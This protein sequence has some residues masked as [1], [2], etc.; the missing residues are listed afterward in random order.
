[1]TAGVLIINTDTPDE[2]IVE[3]IKPYLTEFLMDPAIIGAPC[4][5]RKHIVSHI[6]QTRPQRTV[7]RYRQFWTPQGSPFVITSRAQQKALE[8]VLN[9]SAEKGEPYVVELAMRYGNPSILLGLAIIP[10][11]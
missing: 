1:M 4:F 8:E 3:V 9:A 11:L 7:K 2:P 10:P 6:V 5:V